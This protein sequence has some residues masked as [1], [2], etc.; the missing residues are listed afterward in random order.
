M[1]GMAGYIPG[2]RSLGRCVCDVQND[3]DPWRE[4]VQHALRQLVRDLRR[5]PPLVQQLDHNGPELGVGGHPPSTRPGDPPDR[6]F[7]SGRR[8][9][10]AAV[11]VVAQL[12]ADRGRRPAQPV[13][14]VSQRP[15]LA[16]QV[17]NHRPPVHN[18]KYRGCRVDGLTERAG[19]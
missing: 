10:P 17:G 7:V 1:K 19:A 15:P 13:G 9:I 12:P 5:A 8:Q 3:E 4:G 11:G 18:D 16:S 2:L 6:S 14:D